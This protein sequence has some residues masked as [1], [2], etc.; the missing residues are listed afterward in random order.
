MQHTTAKK[1]LLLTINYTAF[2]LIWFL[3]IWAGTEG[4][5][6]IA[7]PL[8]ISYLV[9]HIV[10]I[11]HCP[12]CEVMLIAMIMLIG[13]S[14]DIVLSKTILTYSS[15]SFYGMSWWTLS[16]WTCF[17]TTYWHTLKWMHSH[18]WT[19]PFLGAIM[20]PLCYL[21]LYNAGAVHF[22]NKG[23]VPFMIISLVWAALLPFSVWISN[24]IAL[25]CQHNHTKKRSQEEE[26]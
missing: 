7:L 23:I 22:H 11:S 12:T 5:S 15:A 13:A 19:T 26:D 25:Y 1:W 17:G 14:N 9:L 3:C 4:T 21:Y 2:Y 20:V 16:L 6:M 18:F 24:T 10:A 8:I